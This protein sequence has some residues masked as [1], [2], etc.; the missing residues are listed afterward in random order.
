MKKTMRGAQAA[1]LFLHRLPFAYGRNIVS[2]DFL[3]SYSRFF[4]VKKTI[5]KYE[6]P[7]IIYVHIQKFVIFC[8]QAQLGTA[9]RAAPVQLE[10][11]LT[12]SAARKCPCWKSRWWTASV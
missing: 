1:S 12:H 10:E 11:L 5:L 4:L 8:F 9:F 6:V 2:S 7:A 3:G